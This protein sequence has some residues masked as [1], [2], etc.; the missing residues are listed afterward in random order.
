[1]QK[2]YFLFIVC[3]S[4]Q[5]LAA[6]DLKQPV[7]NNAVAYLATESSAGYFSFGGLLSGKTWQD[8]TNKAWWLSNQTGQ[9]WSLPP[10]PG[11]AGRL[12]SVAVSANDNVWLFGGYTVAE[13]GTELSL[14][15]VYRVNPH[16]KPIYQRVSDM[17]V[18]VDDATAF[19]Y[20]DRYIYLISGWHDVGNVNLVQMYDTKTDTWQQATPYP[21]NPV[22]GHA[23]G[24]VGNRLLVC[25]GVKIDYAASK[26]RQF[27]G[28]VQCW[29]GEVNPVDLR[30]INWQPVAPMPA[31][32][33]YRSAAA[34]LEEYKRI[35]FIGGSDNP[36]NYDGIGYNGDA[37]EPIAGIVSFDLA[38][39]QWYCHGDMEVASMDHRGLLANDS[40]LTTIGGMQAGQTVSA[41]VVTHTLSAG[42]VCQ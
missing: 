11:A 29:L 6:N 5:L 4:M 2:R 14:A 30:R 15:D 23:G 8:V 18:P 24:M 41:A 10:V 9:W 1:M 12:A 27:T 39:R 22:F 32:S 13:D 19:V 33:R 31:G 20:R 36:Y 35:V 7:T 37:S 3:F 21:G 42:T 34:G 28:S 16:A 26:P 38:S 17:P 40:Q 25:G